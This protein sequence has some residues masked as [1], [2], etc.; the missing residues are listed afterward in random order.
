MVILSSCS[1][2][3]CSMPSGHLCRP[4]CFA[5]LVRMRPA[6]DPAVVFL[7]AMR[8]GSVVGMYRHALCAEYSG[9]C[10]CRSPSMR[11]RAYIPVSAVSATL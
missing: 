9:V 3:T 4:S 5:V 2:S 8:A 6:C 1:L 10:A 7:A 11:V